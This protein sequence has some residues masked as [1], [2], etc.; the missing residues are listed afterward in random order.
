MIS[1]NNSQYRNLIIFV[2]SPNKTKLF[3]QVFNK[4]FPKNTTYVFA[5]KGHITSIKIQKI[6]DYKQ[7][8]QI[9]YKLHASTLLNKIKNINYCPEQDLLILA[10][11]PDRE[12]EAIGWHLLKYLEK[13][14]NI[15]NLKYIRIRCNSLTYNNIV[16]NIKNLENNGEINKKLI[17]VYFARIFIDILIGINGSNLL[18][19]KLQGCKSIGRVQSVVTYMLFERER[20]I[21]DFIPEK[22]IKLNVGLN[23]YEKIKIDRV[24]YKDTIQAKLTESEKDEIVQNYNDKLFKVLETKKTIYN[25][26]EVRPLDIASLS[27]ISNSEFG[28][29]I[30]DVYKICQHLYEGIEIN[31]QKIG[32]I[33]YM[34]TD[35]RL[36]SKDFIPH[37]HQYI[38]DKFGEKYINNNIKESKKNNFSQES[39]EAIRITD[40]TLDIVN[41]IQN[42]NIKERKIAIKIFFHTIASFMT[43]PLYQKIQY[44]LV[45]N[46]VTIYISSYTLVDKGYY[47]IFDLLQEKTPELQNIQLNQND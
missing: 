20:M 32:L 36:V 24:V 26:I 28:M 37:I 45:N 12:G 30:N 10:T 41:I 39:H 5:T 6:T 25:K 15:N 46:D 18:W 43:T 47:L 3:S 23:D 8:F 34:R 14:H 35:S 2:E 7:Q 1:F 40:L 21:Q 42:L 22:F 27:S 38:T 31:N 29:S 44:K 16:S 19:E 17:D 9:V 13:K 4:L 11:D 33:T